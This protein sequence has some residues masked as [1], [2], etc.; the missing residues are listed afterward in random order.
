MYLPLI[1]K[2]VSLGQQDSVTDTHH[3]GRE[4]LGSTFL[5][6]CYAAAFWVLLKIWPSL[7][8]FFLWMLL[9]ALYF[10]AKLFRVLATRFPPSFWVNVAITMLILLGSAVQD[11]ANG[12]DVYQAF[13]VRMGLFI[14]VAIYAGLAVSLLERLRDKRRMPK[15]TLILASEMEPPRC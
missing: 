12:K 1:M 4:L 9:F 2:S 7:W 10:A 14:V 5:G 13:A 6:G 3:A 11:S 8:M 15:R